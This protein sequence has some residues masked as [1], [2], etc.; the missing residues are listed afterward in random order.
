M[1]NL[2]T[3]TFNA[4]QLPA[5]Q[6]QLLTDFQIATSIGFYDDVSDEQGQQTY[7]E[8]AAA[9]QLRCTMVFDRSAQL[10]SRHAA[11]PV[12]TYASFP[13]TLNAGGR[14]PVPLHKI[15]AVTVS[16]THRRRGILSAQMRDDL[17]YAASQGFA[18][19]GL[20]ASEA[21]IYGRFGFE[22][23]TRQ[24][25]FTLKCEGG[26]KLRGQ[27]PGTVVDIDA[28][29]FTE[30]Y[31]DVAARAQQ[32]T[33]GS[34]DGALYDEGYALGR[35]DGYETLAKPKHM[36]FAAS[37]DQQ[38]TLDG[39][40]TYKFAG[41]DKEPARMVVHKLIAVNPAARIKLLAYV[42]NHD[43]VHEVYASG[44]LDDPLRL[45]LADE[46]SSTV[47][48]VDDVLWL[49]VLDVCAAFSRRGYWREGAVVLQ[50]ADELGFAEGRYLFDIGQDSVVVEPLEPGEQ[51]WPEVPEIALGVRELAGLYLGTTSLD[52]LLAVGRAALV[53][54]ASA[55]DCADLFDG[56]SE[57]FTLHGF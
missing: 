24:Q 37:Y 13:G 32:A 26:L 4:H 56:P 29:Q 3:V 54:G 40:I 20:T 5:E 36:R 9:H 21:T 2:E 16:P 1:S 8:I 34:V 42:A 22:V 52:Q 35:W 53:N 23:A 43:L 49:R 31:R 15:S 7:R 10:P 30:Q 51:A 55:Q 28:Q 46:R 48:S 39:F 25:R 45:M 47:R 18:L 41:W 11:A 33:F 19:A 6:M 17:A 14:Q 50:V 44:P 38:G 12:H 27:L 57:P